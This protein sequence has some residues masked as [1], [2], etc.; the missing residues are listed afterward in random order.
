M[1]MNKKHIAILILGMADR[2]VL[3]Y[4]S[5]VI[6]LVPTN[7]IIFM[8]SSVTYATFPNVYIRRTSIS[9]SSPQLA[10]SNNVSIFYIN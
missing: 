8:L 2:S 1:Q 3:V 5:A 4:L 10:D 9:K 7:H 6:Y